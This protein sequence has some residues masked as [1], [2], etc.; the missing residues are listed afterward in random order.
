MN[1]D[2][3]RLGMRESHFVNPNGL[4]NPAHVSSARDMAIVARALLPSFRTMPISSTSARFNSATAT[5]PTTTACL[6]AIPAPMG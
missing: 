3:Q 5:S 1:A 4:H 2:A 6:A